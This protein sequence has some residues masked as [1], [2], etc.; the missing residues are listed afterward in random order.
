MNPRQSSATRQQRLVHSQAK[1]TD[2][3][4]FFNLLTGPQLLEDVEALLPEHRERL[5][6]PAE[7]LSMFIAQALAADGSCK[8][9]LND[10]AV[11]RLVLG[12][13]VC[14][15]NTA[16]CPARRGHVCPRAWSRP[17]RC[18]PGKSSL[19]GP[20]IGGFGAIGGYVWPTA[21]P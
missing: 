16:A 17:W 7:T 11:K 13:P 20:P 3:Y 9:V 15:A 18:V 6:P 12:L 2:A 14:S 10:A 1:D 5:F 21:Q 4:G 8:Q 19:K